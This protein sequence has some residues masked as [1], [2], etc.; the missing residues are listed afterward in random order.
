MP[1]GVMVHYPRDGL[2]YMKGE[3]GA[4]S[5]SSTKTLM[6]VTCERCKEIIRNNADKIGEIK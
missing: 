1:R 3:C 2:T 6:D 5:I 4:N